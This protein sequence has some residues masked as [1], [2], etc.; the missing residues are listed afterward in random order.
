MFPNI[1]PDPTID[2]RTGRDGVAD[3]EPKPTRDDETATDPVVVA[4][5][6][7]EPDKPAETGRSTLPLA[8][9][10]PDPDIELFSFSPTT[11]PVKEPTPEMAPMIGFVV[12]RPAETDPDPETGADKAPVK[13][14]DT[15]P[16]PVR[17]AAIAVLTM[18]A[19]TDPS[20]VKLPETNAD[21]IGAADTDPAPVKLPE[22][23]FEIFPT[24]APSP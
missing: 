2:D 10:L 24:T 17:E 7:P 9:T 1:E 4:A 21:C 19:N 13:T 18:P 12:F 20:P 11:S 3:T 8:N 16:T 6:E 22:T 15:E 5:T 23:G 14:P